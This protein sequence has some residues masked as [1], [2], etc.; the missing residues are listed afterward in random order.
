MNTISLI[1]LIVG[2]AFFMFSSYKGFNIFFNVLIVTALLFVT[3]AQNPITG[4]S[5]VFIPAFTKQLQ[6][7]VL[8]YVL[9]AIFAGQMAAS[10]AA[11]S[12][13]ITF[14]RAL[15]RSSK[16]ETK[17]KF[18]AV[19]SMPLTCAIL[20]YGGISSLMLTFIIVAIWREMFE[21]MDIP[22]HCYGF[23]SIGTATFVL[24]MLPGSPDMANI[25][26][27]RILGTST[28][29][30][31]GLGIIASIVYLALALYY[32]WRTIKKIVAEGEGFMPTGQYGAEEAKL[33]AA[34]RVEQKHHPLIL[35][36][37][38]SIVLLAALN[39]FKQGIIL[40]LVLANVVH[41][42]IFFRYTNFKEA[43]GGGC[44]RGIYTA[45]ILCSTIGLGSVVASVSGF[46]AIKNG[47]ATMTTAFPPIWAVFLT[48]NVLALFT[49]SGPSAISNT[50]N[51]FGEQFLAAG[52]PAEAL[53]RVVS[54]TALGLNTCPNSAAM[55]NSNAVT[56]IPIP[57]IWRH[58]KWTTVIFP[59]V[60]AFVITLLVSFGI[61]F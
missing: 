14:A 2:V 53:H 61:V 15:T 47:V 13:A 49:A 59:L 27:T 35:C 43:I 30:A 51:I 50:L 44:Q 40:S 56:K 29:A 45:C 31:P 32:L 3:N 4:W 33:A 25:I 34:N 48:T 60:S 57:L 6:N 1:G 38:P 8:I 23:A 28:M 19:L 18:F 10:G 17:R 46:E 26:P 24:G 22:W 55:A 9:S 58:F 21:E 12:M 52:V 20:T 5:E 42:V 36:L 16:D 37:L 11:K 39:I 7:Y 54:T 41:A